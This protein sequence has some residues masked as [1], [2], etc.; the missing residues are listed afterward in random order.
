[1]SRIRLGCVRRRWIAARYLG[2]YGGAPPLHVNRHQV[3]TRGKL[4]GV[5]ITLDEL[6]NFR[7][8]RGDHGGRKPCDAILRRNG[9]KT[10]GIDLHADIV[11]RQL[12]DNGWLCVDLGL[13]LPAKLARVVPE[14]DEN[15]AIA[16]GGRLLRTLDGRLP[17]NSLLAM[18]G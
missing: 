13:H 16:L 15:K 14:I 11:R 10:V 17:T 1:L 6:D 5:E 18:A 12:C 9:G 7:A 2:I 4:W 8:R 3:Q